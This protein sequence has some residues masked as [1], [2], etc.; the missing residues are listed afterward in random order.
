[1]RRYA[2]IFLLILSCI[3]SAC[4]VSILNWD[5]PRF[6]SVETFEADQILDVSALC[7]GSIS[8]DGGTSVTERGV[9][10]NTTPNPTMNNNKLSCGTGKGMFNGKIVGLTANKTYYVRAYATT[11][12]GTA[13][14]NEVV[15]TT[16]SLATL[17]TNSINSITLTTATCGGNI[18]DDGGASI[19]ERGICYSNSQNPTTSN[20]KVS[21]GSGAGTYS[22]SISGLTSNTK[23]YV[24]AFAVNVVGTAYGNEVVFTTASLPS[25]TTTAVSLITQTSAQ[26]GGVITNIGSS[27]VI[28]RGICYGQSSNPTI[29]NNK[30]ASGSGTGSFNTSITGLKAGTIYYIRAYATNSSGTAYGNELNFTTSPVLLATINTTIASSINTTSAV[31]GG[32]I[33]N[34]GG[35]TVTTRGI[36]YGTTANPT[37]LNSII[38]SGSGTGIFTSNLTALIPG[39]TYYIRA[40]ATN[41]AGTAYGNNL[42]FTTSPILLPTLSTTSASSITTTSAVSGGNI[43]NDGGGTV[44]ARGVCY[45]TTTN[46]TTSNSKITSGSGTGSFTATLTGLTPSTT[47]YYRAYATNSAG[48]SYG[49]NLSLTTSPISLPSLTTTSASSITTTSAVSGGNITNDGG[50]SVT[51]RGICYSTTTNPTTSNNIVANGSGTGTFTATLTG[52]TP[53]TTYY[54]RAYATNSAG[55]AYGTNLSF[56]T[57][58]VFTIGQSY[59]G[60]IVFYIDGTGLHGLIAALSDQSAGASWGCSGTTINGTGTSVGIG[61]ANTTAIVSGCSTSGIAARLCD[62]LVSNGYSDW[63]LPSLNELSLM[64]TNLKVQGLGSF[65]SAYYWSSSQYSSTNGYVQSFTAN[66]N[67][68]ASKSSS[69]RVRAI[70]SF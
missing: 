48:T 46:P 17:T 3:L 22:V 63:Y 59:Q 54:I 33:T 23:Y 51:A 9:C 2:N 52:L 65:T 70:R 25:L 53:G 56:T 32:N 43:T 36:C 67:A 42:S 11:K 13:Y 14:G 35:G 69:Y 50:G 20:N 28:E 12:V 34:D 10:Y 26:S 41:S 58:P 30:V 27:N 19:S 40:Y 18:T 24:R 6:A 37:I 66:S 49:N 44:T 62:N 29:S 60:G 55:T 7:G 64:Y 47:Y 68:I 5:L 4:D 45:G 15:F 57:T 61:S 1:M 16:V 31:S 8:N 38:A 21:G 39:T